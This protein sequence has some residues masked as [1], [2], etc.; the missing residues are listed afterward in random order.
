MAGTKRRIRA[1]AAI[2]IAA[3]AA[4][5]SLIAASA[6]AGAAEIPASDASDIIGADSPDAIAGEYIVVME[7]QGAK[8]AGGLDALADDLGVNVDVEDTL[9]IVDGYVAQ[10]SEAEA[11]ELAADDAVAYVEQNQWAHASEVQAD[12]PSWGLDRVDQD[13]LPL[14]QSYEYTQSGAGVEAF[15]L[16]TGVNLEHQEFA[17]RIGE[18]YDFIDDDADPADC[19]G[20]GTHVA[21]TIG[22]STYGLAKDVTIRPVRVLD[23]QGSG[24]YAAIIGGIDWVAANAGESAVANMSL[25][26]SFSQALNDSIA[27]AVES[28]VTFAIAAGNEGQDA[29]NVSPGSEPSAITVGATDDDDAAASFTNFGECVDIFAPGVGITSAW[30]DATDAENTI[31]GTSMAAPHVAGVAALFL[32]SNPGATP[33]EV[34][35][36][37]TGG[38]LADVVTEPNGSPNLLLNTAFLG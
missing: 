33:A 18:G 12:P 9:G 5:G 28:G 3:A 7:D 26:G 17:G 10:M 23:C 21:G 16:D 14:D 6:F 31:S 37:L 25:G 4:G 20:H 24:S 34:A 2:G 27:A 36:A 8:A 1:A 22:G 30:I 15:V 11:V 38:A 35:T 19:H 13:A 29:C 32:E